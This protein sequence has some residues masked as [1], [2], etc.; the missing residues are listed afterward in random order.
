[1]AEAEAAEEVAEAEAAP[2]G[3]RPGSVKKAASVPSGRAACTTLA[4][5]ESTR[6]SRLRA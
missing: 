1:M 4:T 2:L 5:L 6:A 3:L